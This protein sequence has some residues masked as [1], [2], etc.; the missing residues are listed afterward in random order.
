MTEQKLNDRIL[1]LIRHGYS[2][3]AICNDI[4]AL[5]KEALPELAKEAGY[6][7]SEEARELSIWSVDDSRELDRDV[8]AKAN[9][10]VKLASEQMAEKDDKFQSA[11]YIWDDFIRGHRL[12]QLEMLKA[13]WRKVEL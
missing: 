1:E 8:W 11:E 5:I 12:G 3:E 4:V 2:P 6:K 7:S 13:G 10:Y 9:G